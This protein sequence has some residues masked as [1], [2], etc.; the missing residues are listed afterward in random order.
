[1]KVDVKEVRQKEK[2]GGDEGFQGNGGGGGFLHSAK[3]DCRSKGRY[4]E[5]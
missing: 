2:D 3:V 4:T 1:M 5:V